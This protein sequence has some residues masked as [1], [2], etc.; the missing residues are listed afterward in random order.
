MVGHSEYVEIYNDSFYI[1]ATWDGYSGDYY[2]ITFP[3]R[4]ALLANHTYNYTIRTGSYPQIIH[5][6]D[7]EA[8]GGIIFCEEFID[9]NGERYDDWIP[10]I[11]LW[12]S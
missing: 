6:K 4:F 5:V 7:Y 8:E 11:R 1:D 10:A 3:S 9:V 12:Y 2:N